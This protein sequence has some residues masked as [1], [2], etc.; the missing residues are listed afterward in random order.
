MSLRAKSF[1]VHPVEVSVLTGTL[2]R[3]DAR[4]IPRLFSR[5]KRE[6]FLPLRVE[7]FFSLIH[8]HLGFFINVFI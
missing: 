3:A 7:C 4:C 8:F 6:G 1:Q 5:Q 2:S